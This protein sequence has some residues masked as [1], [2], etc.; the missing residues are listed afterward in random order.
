VAVN[1][2]CLDTS[3]YSHFQRG[4][5]ATVDLLDAAD[6]IGVPAIV[7]GELWTG[8]IEGRLAD[9]N[10]DLLRAF[11]ANPIVEEI[12]VDREVARLYGEMLATLRKVG[13]TLPTNDVWIAACAARH[14]VPVVTFDAHFK[15]IAR[16]GSLILS[17]TT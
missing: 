1:R 10:R 11:L 6:W 12:V 5:A 15:I 3:A 13:A 7:V 8:F 17:A 2:W 9:Q 16:V 4:H 14:A